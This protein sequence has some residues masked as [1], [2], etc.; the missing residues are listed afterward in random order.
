MQCV[1]LRRLAASVANRI[2]DA[3]EAVVDALLNLT[4]ERVSG[5]GAEGEV[6]Y[7]TKPS[8]RFVS[9]FL[10]PRYEESGQDDETSDIHVS[11]HGLDCQ[12]LDEAGG[13]LEVDVE[14]SIYVR[15]LPEWHELSEDLFPRPTLRKDVEDVI[16]AATADR[17]SR[18]K[19]A[20]REKPRDQ[21]RT[22]RQLQQEIYRE[23]LSQHGVRISDGIVADSDENEADIDGSG[24]SAAS[25][26]PDE[27]PADRQSRL[28]VRNG[29]YYIFDN[30][31]AAKD[32]DIPQ[33]WKRLP[34]RTEPLRVDL[35]DQDTLAS[36]AEAWSRQM[37]LA[38][39]NAVASW[40]A[41]EEGRREAY[42][43]ATLRPSN[44]R[45]I[46][47]W[48]AYWRNSGKIR[49]CSEM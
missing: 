43:P 9:G 47:A 8:L 15:A 28:E 48:N 33:K 23:L 25:G 13:T 24:P 27:Q 41:S 32:V 2:T 29:G 34:V 4:W 14:F 31:Q 1:D 38:I 22:H 37:R 5:S 44:F 45:D 39:D 16:R 7:G 6:I 11:T 40:I 30:D 36:A 35:G 18:A 20:E 21:Q 12:V 17:L 3:N 19:E 42:R 26:E 10:L 46:G 49:R